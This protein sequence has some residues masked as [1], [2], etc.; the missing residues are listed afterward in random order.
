MVI[1]QRG[2]DSDYSFSAVVFLLELS[3]RLIRFTENGDGIGTYDIF[4]YQ[5]TNTTDTLDYSTIGEFSDTHPN[6]ER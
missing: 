1:L 4:Q 3:Q 5:L 2:N 6:D